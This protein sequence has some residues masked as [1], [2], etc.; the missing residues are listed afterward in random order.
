[1]VQKYENKFF[2]TNKK[3]FQAVYEEFSNELKSW[4]ENLS[5]EEKVQVIPEN[6]DAK[7]QLNLA[8]FKAVK[9]LMRKHL[10]KT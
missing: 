10:L 7:V 3:E 1:L 2:F 4:Y 6:K 8:S 9:K 5:D